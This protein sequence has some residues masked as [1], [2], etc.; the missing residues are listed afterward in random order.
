MAHDTSMV[1]WLTLAL[2]AM[3]ATFTAARYFFANPSRTEVEG[4]VQGATNGIRKELRLQMAEI[5]RRLDSQD[6]YATETRNIIERKEERDAKSR[7]EIRDSLHEVS[8][9]GAVLDLRTTKIEQK[10]DGIETRLGAIELRVAGI[11]GKVNAIEGKVDH[12][13]ERLP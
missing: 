13:E 11:D 12:I 5:I 6:R 7:H 8:L 3:I 9:K 10:T 2:A 4:D 1:E